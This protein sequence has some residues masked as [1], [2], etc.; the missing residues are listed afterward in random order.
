MN[1]K[2][3]SNHDIIVGR[4]TTRTSGRDYALQMVKCRLLA[5][6]GEKKREPELGLPWMSVLDRT[7]DLHAMK[8]AI[9]ECIISTP[10]V[11][12]VNS[13]TLT[14]N[15]TTRQLQVA[16]EASTDYGPISDGV[17]V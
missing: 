11:K 12:V 13:L 1:L 9:N 10:H 14:A 3:D 8:M 4:S 2:L 7:Y 17:T 6:L 15:N 16:F 5:F